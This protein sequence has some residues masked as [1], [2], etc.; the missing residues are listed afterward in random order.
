M[1]TGTRHGSNDLEETSVG[2]VGGGFGGLSAAAYLAAAGADVTLYERRESVGGVAGRIERDGFRFDAG[3]SWY[4]MPET[5]ERFFGH[6]GHEPTDFYDLERL[7][8]NYRVFWDDGDH[9]DV[10]A[11]PEAAAALFESYETGA[12][13]AF[14]RYLDDAAD[15]YEIGMN[16]FVVPGRSRCRDYLAA[17]V[18]R[19]GQGL[20]MLCTL[21]EHV[22]SYVEHPKLRQL[23]E[24]TL[25]FLGGSPYNTPALYKLMSH[26]DYGLGVY[27]PQGGIHEV[28]EAVA[29]VA[30]ARG[31]AIRTG[32]TVESIEPLADRIVVET[33]VARDV[34]DRVVCAVSPEYAEREL[35]PDGATSRPHDLVPGVEGYWEG[36]TYGPSAY[37]CYLG[38][39][40]DVEPLAHHTLALP[41][42]WDSHFESIFEDPRWPEDP[43]FYV[44]V[45]SL[46]DPS[47]APE[48]HETIVVLVPLAP[49]L[50]D[51]PE[52]REAFR[53]QVLDALDAYA[54]VDLRGR[55][56][57][58]ETAC[59][60]EFASLLNK[61]HG[62]ALGLAHTLTQ[63]GP[64]RPG[65]RAPGLDRIYY[66]GGGA[67]P[68]IGV[69]MCL[70]SGEHVA[71]A[72]R[73][74]VR[75]TGL[76]GL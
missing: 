32:T 8:P 11:D 1:S 44:N 61:P 9:A 13:D 12:G 2:V 43:A 52:R 6:F 20:T 21:D 34:H 68:G 40:G 46:T 53:S 27:Y 17:E 63:T 3:P 4:L 57:V 48:G 33:E 71:D 58:E 47:V 25:V 72:I 67:N 60:S 19:S 37:M 14:R 15:A 65:Q 23:L 31:T 45:P 75:G 28:V 35:L 26:V 10:P 54:G 69:P 50:D 76:L 51:P 16:R 41:T 73:E 62:S 36:R 39:E 42:D 5:F 56:V 22:R 59:V 7:D 24:Y 64:L 18:I 66:A 29:T 49:G 74:D 38:V 30:R 55:I 70:L